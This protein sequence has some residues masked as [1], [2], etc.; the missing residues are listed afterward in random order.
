MRHISDIH[1]NLS[2]VTVFACHDPL[3]KMVSLNSVL[4]LALFAT[5]VT[6]AAVEDGCRALASAYP[7]KTFF[8]DSERYRFENECGNPPLI[9]LKDN[10]VSLTDSA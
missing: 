4:R 7:D 5:I 3:R 6:S 2:I 8:P 9:Y 1:R 10:P